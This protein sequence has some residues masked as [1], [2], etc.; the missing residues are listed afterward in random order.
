[1]ERSQLFELR[2]GIVE[3]SRIASVPVQ[4]DRIIPELGLADL[5][6]RS[7]QLQVK[8]LNRKIGRQIRRS[9]L[10]PDGGDLSRRS[11]L[12]RHAQH[13]CN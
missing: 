7:L 5:S 8:A 6:G 3:C 1:M 10:N 11:C 4:L 13:I 2:H 9:Y 12:R